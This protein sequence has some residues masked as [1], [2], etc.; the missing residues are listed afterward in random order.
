MV[1]D[2]CIE[3]VW[4]S[5]M[6]SSVHANICF[7]WDT[8]YGKTTDKKKP[9]FRYFAR[10]IAIIVTLSFVGLDWLCWALRIYCTTIYITL[11]YSMIAIVL[12]RRTT[13]TVLFEE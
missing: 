8:G 6:T 12:T 2:G 1:N 9:E 10:L 13:A 5:W 3:L 4:H 7:C 11:F